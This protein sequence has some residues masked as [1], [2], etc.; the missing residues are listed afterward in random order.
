MSLPLLTIPQSIHLL[1]RCGLSEE[2]ER[3][4][5]FMRL[6][7][8]TGGNPR[9]LSL[10]FKS[11]PHTYDRNYIPLAKSAASRY[12]TFRNLGTINREK[13][14]LVNAVL[15]GTLSMGQDFSNYQKLGIAWLTPVV[16]NRGFYVEMPILIIEYYCSCSTG[17]S[18]PYIR[19]YFANDRFY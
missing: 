6:I 13:C 9:L 16:G 18:D 12:L 8:D 15:L 11:L 19:D 5:D 14:D 4:Y 17:N 2:Y 10:I 1:K 3:D 7:C